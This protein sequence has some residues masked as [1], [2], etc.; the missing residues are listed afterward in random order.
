MFLQW[1]L[2]H[3]I[4]WAINLH[5]KDWF[6]LVGFFSKTVY[7]KLFWEEKQLKT[8]FLF[9]TRKQNLKNHKIFRL[10]ISLHLWISLEYCSYI[11]R[12]V[13]IYIERWANRIINKRALLAKI[14]TKHIVVYVSVLADAP[15]PPSIKLRQPHEGQHLMERQP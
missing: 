12:D 3:T 2:I 6:N 9:L 14:P 7:L 15:K 10:L 11:W 8:E 5:N 1:L 4:R 13:L